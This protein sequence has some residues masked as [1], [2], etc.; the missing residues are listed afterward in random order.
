MSEPPT[1][2]T[3][4]KEVTEE[5]QARSPDDFWLFVRGVIIPSASGPQ[6]FSSCMAPFQ[7]EFFR[8]IAPSLHAVRDGKMP[9]DRRFWIERTKKAGKDS[10]L[11][12][13]LLWL[14]AFSKRPFLAQVGAADKDQAAIVR[15]RMKDLLYHNPWLNEYVEAQQYR[16]VHKRGLA[17]LDILAAD[18]PG[19]HGAAPDVLVL[20]ELSHVGKGKWEFLENLLDNADGVPQGLVLIATNAGFKGTKAEVLRKNAIES[21]IWKV[22]IFNR[23]APWLN[24]ADVKEAVK[25]DG[26][27]RGNRLWY[28]K[29]A[30]GKGDALSEDDIDRCFR[31]RLGP[32]TKPKRGWQYIGA[33]DLGVS[34]DHSGFL[35]LGIDEEGQRIRVAW[36]RGW[37]PSQ[38]TGKVDLI[39][40]EDTCYAMS[41]RFRLSWLGF[42]PFEAE[43][44]AQRL[45]RRGVPMQEWSFK[46][47]SNLNA[48]AEALVKVVEAGKLECYED[49]E[50]RLRR[51][52]GKFNIVEKSY[53]YKLEAVSDEHGHADVGTALVIA[54]PQAVK[55]MAGGGMSLSADDVLWEEGDD[56]PLDERAV[57][58]L[59][60]E[61]RG[62][63]EAE[64]EE[65]KKQRY[66][67][68]AGEEYPEDV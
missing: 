52:F 34:H 25:R 50:G 64:D 56:K 38:R 31:R 68:R 42:D 36:F 43:L 59:P 54:L 8:D 9:I 47:P 15:T 46:K 13:I 14:I 5:Y 4:A 12:I 49:E 33:L 1:I 61:L 48:M 22:Q 28:G 67:K 26:K 19:S 39:E 40:V 65:E 7:A 35:I 60:E 6:L 3:R 37:A 51:D 29:W 23:P 41:R 53:G 62:I 30:S 16:I 10:D 2:N 58:G 32:I 20:N 63:Y 21:E 66:R 11:A 27:S 44:M 45:V 18:I 57:K 24:K 17:S 55:M